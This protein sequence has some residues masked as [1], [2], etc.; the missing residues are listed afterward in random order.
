VVRLGPRQRKTAVDMMT[1]LI[2]LGLSAV[3]L[4]LYITA[5]TLD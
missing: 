5:V 2:V 4:Q 1:I 3:L